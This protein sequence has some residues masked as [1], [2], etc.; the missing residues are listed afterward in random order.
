MTILKA[1]CDVCHKV[2][3]GKKSA[4]LID[5]GGH[6]ICEVCYQ[7]CLDEILEVIDGK[8]KVQEKKVNVCKKR[9]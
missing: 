6:L 4:T 5:T 7:K 3:D 1:S 8:W 2:F 9:G